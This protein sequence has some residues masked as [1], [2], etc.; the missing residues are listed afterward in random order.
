MLRMKF[1]YTVKTLKWFLLYRADSYS[2]SEE[3]EKL[4]KLIRK[5]A[6]QLYE[7]DMILFDPYDLPVLI[8]AV[9]LDAQKA[10]SK[11][12]TAPTKKQKNQ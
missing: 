2:D 9:I 4:M 8:P 5:R 6:K 10:L 12:A 11:K 3:V 1:Q 7:M